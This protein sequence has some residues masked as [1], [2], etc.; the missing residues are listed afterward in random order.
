MINLP[1]ISIDIKLRI[2]QK[3]LMVEPVTGQNDSGQLELAISPLQEGFGTSKKLV[4]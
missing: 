3:S 4:K 1:L 2:H